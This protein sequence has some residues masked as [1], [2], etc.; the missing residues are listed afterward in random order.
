MVLLWHKHIVQWYN[1]VKTCIILGLTIVTRLFVIT[2]P[3]THSVGARIATVVG[4]CLSS[5]SVVFNTASEPGAWAIEWPTLH[6]GT[7]RLRPVRATP[8]YFRH[9]DFTLKFRTFG[10][11]WLVFP[12]CR[13][14]WHKSG[15]SQE[16]DGN[17]TTAC[18]WNCKVHVV[19][20]KNCSYCARFVGSILKCQP[21]DTGVKE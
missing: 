18:R 12:G 10:I 15:T 8:G 6:R 17:P 13:T 7:V 20:T 19:H 4:V 1:S 9:F 2:G 5:S 16:M 14:A 21:N 3:P 11:L